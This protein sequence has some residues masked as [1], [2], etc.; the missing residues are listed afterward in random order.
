MF[1]ITTLTL[2]AILTVACSTRVVNE[3]LKLWYTQAADPEIW[4]EAL[5]IGNG[6]LGGMVYGNPI[7][8]VIQFNEETLWTGEP[9]E[10]QH[11]E[12]YTNLDTLRQL[13]FV[14]KQR[15]ADQLAMQHVMSVPLR[16]KAYQPFGNLIIELAGVEET[17]NYHRELDLEEAMTRV[18]F[19]SEGLQYH[20]ESWVSYPDQ[21][22]AVRLTVNAKKKLNFDIAMNSPHEGFQVSA[23]DETLILRVKVQNG[24]L[25]GEARAWIHETDGQVTIKDSHVEVRNASSALVLLTAGTSFRNYQAV[26]QNPAEVCEEVFESVREKTFKQLRQDHITDYASLFDTFDLNFG[27]GLDNT[28]TN[29]R[30]LKFWKEP[31]DPSLLALYVQYGRYLMISSSRG[32]GQPAN[33]QGIWNEHLRPPWDS[34]WTVNI[35]A[36]MNYWP[37]EPTGLEACASPLFKLIEECA[38]SGAKVAQEHYRC[39]GWVLHHN[40]DVW[41]GTA[42]INAANHGIWVTGGAWL[43]THMWEHYLFGHD[44]NFLRERAW[45]VMKGCAEF[46]VDYLVEDPVTGWL[47]SGPSNSPENGGLVMGPTM[48]HQIIRTLFKACIEAADILETDQ[49]LKETLQTMVPKIAPN[50]IGQYGQ[51]QEWLTDIDNPNNKHRHVSHLWGMHPGNDITWGQPELMNAAKQSLLM[52]GDEGT[53]WSLAWK[54]NFWARLHDGNH[55]YKLVHML[56]SPAEHP[57]RSV[58][59][60]SYPNLFDAHPPFQIDGNFGGAAGIIEMLIQ[61]HTGEIVLLP[62]LPDALA[63]GSVTGVRARGG[64]TLDFSWEEHQL[65]EVRVKSNAGSLC[66]LRYKKIGIE[67]D[68]EEGKQFFLNGKLV[69]Q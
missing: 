59:G 60:G 65:T 55:A 23:G 67:F 3:D 47:I 27:E 42:P 66:T 36:E 4:E 10:Y 15:E 21:V 32:E 29:E 1:R 61:S 20:R 30:I 50:Q 48:D 35:N 49:K 53:G 52:R 22:M 11:P 26:D 9:H 25:E 68:T 51:L 5:P 43:T 57:D 40:T 6:R 45:P 34:K 14:G 44:V 38:E 8:E 62:A 33:L 18:S 19:T 37:V 13:L 54:I 56:L 24:V 69:M 16:Q 12:A 58:R 39:R 64:F 17:S 46:F 31:A 2:A 63:S 7:R 41:R 28:P